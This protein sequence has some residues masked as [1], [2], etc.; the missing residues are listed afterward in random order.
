M[1]SLTLGGNVEIVIYNVIGQR[2]RTLVNGHRNSGYYRILWDGRDDYRI[3]WD[4]RDD[5]DKEVVSGIYY[6]ELK[7]EGYKS[8]KKI[9]M[10]R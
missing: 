4:G 10:I 3:L 5:R 8:R 2:I 6:Y 1:Y 7:T 9:E